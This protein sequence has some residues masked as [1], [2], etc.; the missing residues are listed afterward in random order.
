MKKII[1]VNRISLGHYNALVALGYTI[2]FTSKVA[3]KMPR[4]EAV[5]KAHPIVFIGISLILIAIINLF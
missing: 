3:N 4:P 2:I 5:F 1:K